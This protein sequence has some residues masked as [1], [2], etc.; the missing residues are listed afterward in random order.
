MLLWSGGALFDIGDCCHDIKPRWRHGR[1][2]TARRMRSG[3][4]D[5]T[6]GPDFFV[7]GRADTR[8]SADDPAASMILGRHP[9]M[10]FRPSGRAAT[11]LRGT[12]ESQ[13]RPWRL[14]A[15]AAGM[16]GAHPG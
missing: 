15:D 9:F 14:G 2:Y 10:L 13:L 8:R 1:I 12:D 5:T 11:S 4:G 16:T 6:P 7:G 3:L